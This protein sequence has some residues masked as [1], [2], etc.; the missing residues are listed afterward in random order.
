MRAFSS[1]AT[2]RSLI[3]CMRARRWRIPSSA[4][5][6]SDIV[7]A[8]C[9]LAT[10][11]GLRGLCGLVE[12][13]V[14]ESGESSWSWRSCVSRVREGLDDI[15]VSAGMSMGTLGAVACASSSAVAARGRREEDASCKTWG[16]SSSSTTWPWP[17][18]PSSG[19][20]NE[21]LR[22]ACDSGRPFGAVGGVAPEKRRAWRTTGSIIKDEKRLMR[23]C[24]ATARCAMREA[25]N[26]GG[27]RGLVPRLT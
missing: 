24:F 10:G 5:S 20:E 16:A 12:A 14:A 1:S 21:A 17:G 8:F 27:E 11:F 25:W 4:G 18:G 23:T 3:R 15:A 26:A 2:A 19:V 13:G 7:D 6:D 9:P 22:L